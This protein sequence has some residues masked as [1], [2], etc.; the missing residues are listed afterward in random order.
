MIAKIGILLILLS[1]LLVSDF[2]LWKKAE[3]PVKITYIGI[4][5]LGIAAGFF[6]NNH[7]F[8]IPFGN[9]MSSINPFPLK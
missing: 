8:E 4:L 6:M 3:L 9:W 2:P 5:C 7:A 1:I